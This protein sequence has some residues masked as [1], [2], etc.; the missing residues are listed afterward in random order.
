[1][2]IVS[3]YVKPHVE[4]TVYEFGSI[5]RFMEDNWGLGTLG[6]NDAHSVSI[7]NAFDF[8]MS[9]RKFQKIGAKYSR[10][11]FLHQRPSGKPPDTE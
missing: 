7:G 8:N 4:H 9:P 6:K 5:L 1:M 11:F 10:S 3:P 2:L